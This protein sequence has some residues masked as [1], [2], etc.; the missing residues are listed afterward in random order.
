MLIMA[1][2]VAGGLLSV[3]RIERILSV[4]YSKFNGLASF[5]KGLAAHSPT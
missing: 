3:L 5:R 4:A 2:G 1:S